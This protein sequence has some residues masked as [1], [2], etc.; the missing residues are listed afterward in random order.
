MTAVS[1]R[2]AF[3]ELCVSTLQAHFAAT[4]GFEG[5]TVHYDTFG[6]EPTNEMVILGTIA[7]N[8]TAV[9]FGPAGSDDEFTIDTVLGTVGHET[10]VI[11]DRRCQAILNEVNEALFKGRFAYTLNGRAF[12]GKQDGPNA[13][14]AYDG[15]LAESTVELTIGCAISVRGA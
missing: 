11:A 7:G 13:V 15:A 14:G 8:S 6:E 4:E 9:V 5:V 1:D 12:P 10:E 3:K 2:V